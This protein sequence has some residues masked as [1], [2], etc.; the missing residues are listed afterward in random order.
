MVDP[1]R[2]L[3]LFTGSIFVSVL[4]LFYIVSIIYSYY[5]GFAQT[6][7]FREVY[8]PVTTFAVMISILLIY[9]YY[10]SSLV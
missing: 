7:S 1:K 9:L 8:L 3:K 2:R 10:K 6:V 5:I 4:V